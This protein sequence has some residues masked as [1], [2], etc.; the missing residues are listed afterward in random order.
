MVEEKRKLRV[1]VITMGGPRQEHIENLFSHPT[2][3]AH[4]D[5]PIFSPGIPQRS[6]RN[7][8]E[9][10]R[11]AN[12]AG[13]LPEQ[14]WEA[15]RKAQ[16]SG[17]HEKKP[18][19]FFDCLS[20][21]PVT[22]GRRGSAYDVTIHYSV[23][24]WRKAKTI[25]RGRTVLACVLAHLIAIKKFVSESFDLILEDNVRAPVE[26][27]ADRIW[28]AMAA[29]QEW[30][31]QGKNECHY[32]FHGWLGSILNLEWTLQTHS[33]KREY[34]RET[35]DTRDLSRVTVFPFPLAEHLEVDLID[36][37]DGTIDHPIMTEK[38]IE[39]EENQA[40][41]ADNK[42]SHTVPGGNFIWGCYAYWLSSEAYHLLLDELRND[43]GAMLWKGKRARYYSVKPIDKILP[44]QVMSLCG[45]SSVQLSTHPAFFRA[46]ML[47]SKI[48]TQFDPEFCKSTEYQL[49]NTE[50]D[51]SKLWLNNAEE[52]IVEHHQANG[53]WLTFAELEILKGES[54]ADGEGG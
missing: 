16:E 11:Y 7:R 52:E 48:H 51:W 12:E 10:L 17:I 9:F 33:K 32:L 44:R 42:H 37:K 50:L 47:T 24:F 34:K 30:C 45:A 22:Q 40:G 5:K 39:K 27:C 8:Y 38:Q 43:V 29:R 49:Q 2:M 36:M 26:S 15:I 1:L 13:L 28:E 23:E 6:L 21:I 54:T 53:R 35:R 3:S 46:P 25:N 14:E 19:T 18:E 41:D 20:D 31:E 4:F